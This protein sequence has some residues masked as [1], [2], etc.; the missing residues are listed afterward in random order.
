MQHPFVAL[1]PEYSQLLAAMA[2][3]PECKQEVDQ[4]ATKLLGYKSRYQAVTAVG[5]VPVIFIASSFE[6][7]AS[8]NFKLNPAQGWPLNSISKWIP[9]NGPFA[10]WQSAA[11]A[12]YH[13]NG[14]DKVGAENW[15]WEQICYYGESFNGFGY[16][17]YHHMHTP[18]LWGGTNIQTVGKYTSDG[19]FDASH[20]DTQLGIIPV[21]RRMV[22][23]DSSLAIASSPITIPIPQPSGLS[24]PDATTEWLQ[25][26]INSLG[27][28]PPLGVDGNYGQQTK[29]AVAAFQQNYGLEVD[30]LAGPETIAALKS[31]LAA[32]TA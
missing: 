17:D 2:V 6:R 30:G 27:L 22:E 20:M 9:H 11:V 5:G 4:V 15:T 3:R 1:K 25:S 21:A 19:K 29:L 28:E 12:A 31:A 10:D 14:L 7:E 23:L 24:T 13:L 16:R 8:T 32:L 18:Y 26:S